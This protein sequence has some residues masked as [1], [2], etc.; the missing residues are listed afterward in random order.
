MS[1]RA[2]PLMHT[3]HLTALADFYERLG[4]VRHVQH[5]DDTEPHFV[6]LR[7]DAAEIALSDRSS[8][9]DDGAAGPPGQWHMVVFVEAV[10]ATLH[11][12]TEAGVRVIR[13]PADMP[14][15]E[16]MASVAD[17]EGNQVV[18]ASVLAD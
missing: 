10:D 12:L 5:P 6:V 14:W 3:R 18:L 7:R 11:R 17:P 8:Q 2:F 1:L 4:F 9:D 16:R 15:G 13:E